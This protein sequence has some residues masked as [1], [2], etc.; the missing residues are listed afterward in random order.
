[1]GGIIFGGRVL[2][3][4]G[5]GRALMV[6]CLYLVVVHGSPYRQANADDVDR[7]LR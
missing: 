1:M 4:R 7:D 2:P 5:L 6:S 3:H